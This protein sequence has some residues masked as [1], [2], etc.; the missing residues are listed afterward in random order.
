[1]LPHATAFLSQVAYLDAHYVSY[2]MPNH[3]N[4]TEA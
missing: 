3:L 2:R 4:S 1:M